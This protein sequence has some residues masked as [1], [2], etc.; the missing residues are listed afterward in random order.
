M[1]FLW[2]VFVF[3][4]PPF[5]SSCELQGLFYFILKLFSSLLSLLFFILWKKVLVLLF[6]WRFLL[7]G[8]V[9]FWLL[10]EYFTQKKQARL[11]SGCEKKKLKLCFFPPCFA[12]HV[13]YHAWE[14]RAVPLGLYSH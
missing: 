8:F 4:P 13:I 1:S 6:M 9:L 10:R 11:S 2:V 14:S 12:K 3:Y 7:T 5:P